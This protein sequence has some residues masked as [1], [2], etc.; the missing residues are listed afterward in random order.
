MTDLTDVTDLVLTIDPTHVEVKPG[1]Q[2]TA[3]ASIQ[4]LSQEMAYY[5]LHVEG[6]PPAWS[7]MAPAQ[8]AAFPFEEVQAQ[9]RIQPP[10]NATYAAYNLTVWAVAPGRGNAQVTARLDVTVTGPVQAAAPPPLAEPLPAPTPPPVAV[11]EP[12]TAARIAV[13]AEPVRDAPLP[14]QT[15]QWRLLLHNQSD[16]PDTF[17]IGVLGIRPAWASME[18]DLVTLQPDEKCSLLLSVTPGDDASV[19]IHPFTLRVLSQHYPDR[20]AELD[21]QVEAKANAAF[22]L[23]IAPREAEA[24]G[25]SEFEIKIISDEASNADTWISLVAGDP[26]Q[27]AEYIFEPARVLL[28]ARQT[29]TAKLY[30]RPRHPAEP[31]AQRAIVFTAVAVRDGGDRERRSVEARLTQ[32]GAASLTLE[33]APRVQSDTIEAEY[34]VMATNAAATESTLTLSGEDLHEACT[35]NFD[36]PRLTVPPHSQ[37]QAMLKVRARAYLELEAERPHPCTVT[38]TPAGESAP[39]ARAN[40]QFTQLSIPPVALELTPPHQSA[41][42]TARYT[43]KATNPRP[44]PVQLALSAKDDRNALAFTLEP[45]MLNLAPGAEAT[46]QLTVQAKARLPLGER[47]AHVFTVV[48]VMQGSSVEASTTGLLAQ[49]RSAGQT[50]I[51]AT[52]LRAGERAAKWALVGLLLGFLVLLLLAGMEVTSEGNVRLQAQV[53]PILSHPISRWFL[54]LPIAEPARALVRS[55]NQA[56][57]AVR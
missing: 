18:S 21:L 24:P 26:Q 25:M 47:R 7:E 30:V 44:I 43:I 29:A 10:E 27:A 2:V 51:A 36:P 34:L 50:R 39:I 42:R 45:A 38:A 56:L 53:A 22:T 32:V 28:T 9:V 40:G 6:L 57:T 23:D 35:Y 5:R 37:A 19:G 4:N 3:I 55:L 15:A 8:I 54:D 49:E 41:P 52:L 46:S 12:L 48:G 11:P 31:G 17:R 20:R 16:D 33:L 14:P 13:T 1:E